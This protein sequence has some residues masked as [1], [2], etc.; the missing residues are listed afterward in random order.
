MARS[1]QTVR[2]DE[3]GGVWL[4]CRKCGK[5]RRYVSGIAIVKADADEMVS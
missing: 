1:V 4:V 3:R 5:E 2:I